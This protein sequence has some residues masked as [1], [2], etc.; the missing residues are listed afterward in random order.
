MTKKIDTKEVRDLMKEISVVKNELAMKIR[1]IDDDS[2]YSDSWKREQKS[3]VIEKALTKLSGISERADSVVSAFEDQL[4][5]PEK[6][7]Y[8]DPELIATISFIQACGKTIP[9]VAWKQ[10]IRDYSG[11][12]SELRLLRDE[13][14]KSGAV[15]ASVTANDAIRDIDVSE[16]LPQRI[17]DAIY[18]ACQTPDVTDLSGISGEIEAL[19]ISE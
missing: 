17:G 8:S 14:Q 18:Y 12:P 15:K 6:F 16:S 4:K 5:T 10:I 1:E 9:E 7:N 2:I 19:E 13:F 11:K 3:K